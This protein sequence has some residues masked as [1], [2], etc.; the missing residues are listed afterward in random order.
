MQ[1]EQIETF[2][3]ALTYTFKTMLE[4]EV[5]PSD[6]SQTK[7]LLPPYSISALVGFSGDAVGAVVLSLTE[8]TALK[9]ASI[10]LQEEITELDV[11][12]IDAV[13][14]L[15]NVVVGRAKAQMTSHELSISL[16]N[17]VTG[18]D[19]SVM[20]PRD[21]QPFFVP[22]DTDCGPLLLAVGLV[23]GRTKQNK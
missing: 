21:V 22:C 17:V 1:A 3:D 5:R 18:K 19:H 15:T 7:E 11:D 6:S 2:V 14:E 20:F 8:A 4:C 16:P 10:L 23:N 12:A 9:A 13:G